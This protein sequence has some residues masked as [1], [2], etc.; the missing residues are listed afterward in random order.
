MSDSVHADDTFCVGLLCWPT[1]KSFIP[2]AVYDAELN[3]YNV[4]LISPDDVGLV[5]CSLHC[6]EAACELVQVLELLRRKHQSLLN[7]RDV[8]FPGCV[9]EAQKNVLRLTMKKEK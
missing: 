8:N 3:M 2:R 6:F 9:A 7:H 1:V 4:L 5:V